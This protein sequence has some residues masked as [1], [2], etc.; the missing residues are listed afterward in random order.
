MFSGPL[1]SRLFFFDPVHVNAEFFDQVSDHDPSVVRV[2]LNDAPSAG[3]GGP[4]AVDEGSSVALTASGSD[5]DGDPLTFAWDLDGNGSFETPGQSVSF[6]GADGPSSPTVKVRV[7]DDGG[8]SDVAQATVNVGNLAPTIASLDASPLNALVDQPV[9]FTGSATD[10]SAVD[11]AAG[12]TWSFDTG[13]GFGSFGASPFTTSFSACG[14]Y[15]VSAKAQDKD[16]GVSEPAAAP[17]VHVYGA[18]LIPPLQAGAYN[19]VQRGRVVPVKITVGCGGF[20]SGLRPAIS[21]RAGDF[22]PTVDPGDPSYVVPDSNSTADTS[23]VMREGDGQYIYNL[24]VPSD[25]ASGQLYTVLVRPFG[26]SAPA[27]YAVL[28]IK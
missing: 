16:G 9:T 11:Q 24:A 7:T 25:A 4:Y 26:G 1:F 28:K 3:A 27:L 15:T 18:N 8:A 2:L 12:F 17:A 23:G 5:P 20:L 14:T 21:L 10:P 6:F 22:D 19:V 13:S